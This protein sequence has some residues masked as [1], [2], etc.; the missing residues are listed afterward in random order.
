MRSRKS[1]LLNS[2][3]KISDLENH[4]D[5]VYL[6]EKELQELH[7]K[8]YSLEESISSY[9]EYILNTSIKEVDNSLFFAFKKSYRSKIKLSMLEDI[10][11]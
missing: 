11:L 9:F 1:I 3:D 8:L 10:L 6:K 2:I 4:A 5:L 7:K